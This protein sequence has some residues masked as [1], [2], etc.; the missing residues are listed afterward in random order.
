M[1]VHPA[2]IVIAL[3]AAMAVSASLG[4][5]KWPALRNVGRVVTPVR[6]VTDAPGSRS[7]ADRRL[8]ADLDRA[9]ELLSGP[10]TA[11]A[12]HLAER[13]RARLVELM[14]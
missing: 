6:I 13:V 5:W 11:D 7:E 8:L 12:L 1:R 2:S 3:V 10:A 4:E 9:I 14:P